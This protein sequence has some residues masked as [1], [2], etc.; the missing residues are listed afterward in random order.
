MSIINSTDQQKIFLYNFQRSF[1]ISMF[2]ISFFPSTFLV[3]ETEWRCGYGIRKAASNTKKKDQVLSPFL[4]FS[5][6]FIPIQF[7]CF[8]PF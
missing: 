6:A 8:F 7:C 3:Q 2:E 5:S 4:I 1:G